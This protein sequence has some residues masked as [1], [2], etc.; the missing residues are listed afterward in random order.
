[1]LIKEEIK[2]EKLVDKVYEI[3]YRHIMN[4]TLKP[5]ERIV[6][7]E[8]TEALNV[9]RTPLREAI[10]QLLRNGLLVELPRK[11]GRRDFRHTYCVGRLCSTASDAFAFR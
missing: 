8:I 3:L 9:S 7:S 4:Q 1:M 2:Q 5:G 10:A 6:E 11:G